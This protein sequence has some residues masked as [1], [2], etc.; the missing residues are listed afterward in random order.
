MS[1]GVRWL[2]LSSPRLGARKPTHLLGRLGCR[3]SASA[4][5]VWGM[6]GC[7]DPIP[8]LKAQAGAE[9]AKLLAGMNPDNAAYLIGTD[10]PR[11]AESPR[12]APQAPEPET[13][14]RP[15]R[16]PESTADRPKS[17]TATVAMR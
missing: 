1:F 6:R 17:R 4:H 8:A 3:A 13:P 12:Y 5:A 2:R 15:G 7:A 11:I 16:A 14:Y 9:I 10:A